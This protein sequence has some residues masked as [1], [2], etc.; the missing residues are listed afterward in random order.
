Q[1]DPGERRDPCDEYW[2]RFGKALSTASYLNQD[3]GGIVGERITQMITALSYLGNEMYDNWTGSWEESPGRKQIVEQQTDA[4][5]ASREIVKA[6]KHYIDIFQYRKFEYRK[7]RP[8]ESAGIAQPGTSRQPTRAEPRRI[9]IPRMVPS[10]VPMIDR[11]GPSSQ[12]PPPPPLFRSLPKSAE[13]VKTEAPDHS[14]YKEIKKE[15]VDVKEEPLDD[16]GD[17]T[18]SGVANGEVKQEEPMSDTFSPSCGLGRQPD[19]TAGLP[20]Y[21]ISSRPAN[22]APGPP[23][24]FSPATRSTAMPA[25]K[26]IIVKGSAKVTKDAVVQLNTNRPFFTNQL[27]DSAEDSLRAKYADMRSPKKCYL[28]EK[29]IFAYYPTPTNESRRKSFLKRIIT[30]TDKERGR[31]EILKYNDE[32]RHFCATHVANRNTAFSPPPPADPLTEEEKRL[33]SALTIPKTF[34]P[35]FT[36]EFIAEN[37]ILPPPRP[38]NLSYLNRRCDLCG[39]IANPFCLSPKDQLI[40]PKFFDNLIDLTPEQRDRYEDYLQKGVRATVCRKHLNLA[41]T[42]PIRKFVVEAQ[43]YQINEQNELIK[44]NKIQNDF[45]PVLRR[46]R[47]R[48]APTEIDVPELVMVKGNKR[49][50]QYQPAPEEP[51]PILD[52]VPFKEESRDP[53]E[54]PLDKPGPSGVC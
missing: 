30:M 15:P 29:V 1:M 28:C 32:I 7:G 35:K 45:P 14:D 4:L 12:L 19:L 41:T 26:T 20:V 6:L 40:A 34:K 38:P 27:V 18:V 13:Q 3:V 8:E 31:V 23:V 44:F 10:I 43:R 54:E 11:P 48:N 5:V 17:S 21:R 16:Y 52:A 51:M 53:K 50:Q 9:V 47:K 37:N 49:K 22:G 2:G 36:R 33:Q 24:P 25:T 39:E 42:T 46:A